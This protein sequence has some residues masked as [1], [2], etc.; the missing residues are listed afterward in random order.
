M[1][2]RFLDF[3]G[4]D[5]VP[6]VCERFLEQKSV[7]FRLLQRLAVG[8]F[9]NHRLGGKSDKLFVG[10]FVHQLADGLDGFVRADAPVGEMDQSSELCLSSRLQAFF[11]RLLSGC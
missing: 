3:Y 10:H 1:A 8:A 4:S 6:I 5:S 7:L 9:E 2:V 11:I